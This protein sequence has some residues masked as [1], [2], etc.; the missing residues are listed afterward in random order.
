MRDA[1]P[2]RAPPDAAA[3]ARAKA[4]GTLLGE[5]ETRRLVFVD[6][7]FVPELSDIAA[8]EPGLAV[9]SLADALVRRRSAARR[10]SRQARAGK[11]RR[12]RAQYRADGRRCGD[13]HRRRLRPSSGRCIC[14]SSPRT[15]PAATFV[16]SLVVVEARRARH[17]DREPRRA[18]PAAI[19]RSTP[20][21]NCS[22]ATRR[23]SITSRSSARAPTRC[24]SRRWRRRSARARA[25]T[26][27][28]SP[29]AAPWCATSCS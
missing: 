16:R 6:G 28:P 18:R 26:R 7:A 2:L 10:A 9:G 14:C 15:K 13:P 12:G 24:T 19:I 1:K 8:L 22:S 20:R 29:P 11:R 27:S 21:S 25:S 4:A 23:T 17:A 5:I 3:K